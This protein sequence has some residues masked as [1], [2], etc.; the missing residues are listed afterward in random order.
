MKKQTKLKLLISGIIVAVLMAALTIGLIIVLLPKKLVSMPTVIFNS[1]QRALTVFNTALKGD[2]YGPV[3]ITVSNNVVD[4]NS[5][6]SV[7]NNVV[8][9][10]N[11]DP[12]FQTPG[13][14][15][16]LSFVGASWPA[17]QANVYQQAENFLVI[18]NNNQLAVSNATVSG[19]WFQADT[20][21]TCYP[22]VQSLAF[23][24]N[25]GET[26]LLSSNLLLSQATNTCVAGNV[27]IGILPEQT[28][29]VSAN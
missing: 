15:W 17:I 23:S 9:L 16:S 7:T 2:L 1:P 20:S 19:T 11:F 8:T 26:L 28:I 3:L 29:Y 22:N 5:I 13:Q 18:N 24:T 27:F 12:T 25:N 6:L 14:L 4:S 21:S 10:A